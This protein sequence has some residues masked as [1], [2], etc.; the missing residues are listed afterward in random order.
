MII[1]PA[2][3]IRGGA[4]VRLLQGDFERETVYESDPA[5]VA[6]RY[7]EAGATHI[8]VVDLDGARTGEPMNDEIIRRIAR[9][10]LFLQTGGGIRSIEDIERKLALGANRVVLGTAAVKNP[11]FVREA[12]EKFGEAV[13]V[14]ID[15][16]DGVVA[17]SGWRES[18]G[19]D[20]FAFAAEVAEAGVST[21]IFTDIARDGMMSGASVGETARLA[22]SVPVKI[23]A[24]GGVSSADDLEKL[25]GTRVHGAIIGK[26]LFTGALDLKEVIEKYQN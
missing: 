24:S 18:S 14:G 26:A 4:A 7:K 9:A 23:I 11:G 22:E 19:A 8:H 17:V 21:I 1:Y 12:V 5:A 6:R 25:S 3:D 10:G 16:R 20:A 15:A 2:V 13:A